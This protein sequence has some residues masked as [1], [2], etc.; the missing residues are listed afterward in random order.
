L[1]TLSSLLTAAS[2]PPICSQGFAGEYLFAFSEPRHAAELALAF[3]AAIPH[4]AICL[5]A[6]PV[7]MEVNPV[8]HLYAPEGETVCRAGLIAARLP[9]GSV[10]A[11]ETFTAISALNSLRGFRFEHSGGIE[12]GGKTVRLFRVLPDIRP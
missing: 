4:S 7:R 10:S 5:H 8:L 2:N 1:E 12:A 9:G 6:G 3:A 11:T